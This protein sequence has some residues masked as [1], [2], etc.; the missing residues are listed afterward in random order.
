MLT[1]R[2][3]L[4]DAGS[5]AWTWTGHGWSS[6]DS[7]IRPL[8]NSVLESSLHRDHAGRT[9]VVVQERA[10]SHPRDSRLPAVV[11]DATRL[12]PLSQSCLREFLVVWWEPGRVQVRAGPFGTAPLLLATRGDLL[13]A[14]WH[15]PDLASYIHTDQPLGRA[16][17]RRLS[18]QPRYTSDTVFPGV[19][20]LTERATATFTG[21]GLTLRYPEPAEHVLRPR[22]LRLGVDVVDGFSDLLAEV[23]H[24]TPAGSASAGT[25]LSGGADSAAVAR[26]ISADRDHPVPSYGL[27]LGGDVGR[28]QRRRRAAMIDRFNL[29]DTTV[30]AEEHPPFTPT[31]VRGRGMP[32]DPLAAYYREAFDAMRDRVAAAGTPVICTGLGGDELCTSPSSGRRRL[33]PEQPPWL[34]PASRAVIDDVDTNIAPATVIPMTSLMAQASHNPAYLAAR[35]WPVAPLAHPTLV[36]FAEQLPAPWRTGKR[37]LRRQLSRAGLPAHVVYPSRPETFAALMQTGLRRYGLPVL[38]GMLAESVLVDLGYLDHHALAEA[39]DDAITAAHLPSTL[40]DA[41]TLEVGLRSL[42]QAGCRS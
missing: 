29:D 33:Q 38:K 8:S 21:S 13:A 19:Q 28:Q 36:R 11:P 10:A 4:R 30:A 15:L 27:I 20:R 32:H 41:L 12:V 31:G 3:H 24:A 14:S 26:A 1:A 34:G 23:L 7:W 9:A 25:E 37:L 2:L 39:Y 42:G 5:S 40:C 6:G 17:A 18:R 35:I 22:R 16:I